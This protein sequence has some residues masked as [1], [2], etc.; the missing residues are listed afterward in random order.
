MMSYVG[1]PTARSR[2]SPPSPYSA[3]SW[4]SWST[5]WRQVRISGCWR[6]L[7]K[8]AATRNPIR[9]P[10]WPRSWNPTVPSAS[11]SWSATP[12]SHSPSSSA[13]SSVQ[14]SNIPVCLLS[15]Q[16]ILF[17]KQMHDKQP[18]MGGAM[19]GLAVEPGPRNPDGRGSIP[20]LGSR[21]SSLISIDAW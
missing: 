14:T 4:T 12:G 15:I 9:P 20:R 21:R 11:W 2:S 8:V 16:Y 5:L 6:F 18:T 13:S 3:S 10:S 7:L 17:V 19:H 1:T